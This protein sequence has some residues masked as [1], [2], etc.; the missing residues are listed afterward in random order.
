MGR[1]RKPALRA[2]VLITTVAMVV[3]NVLAEALPLFGRGTGE[4]SARYPVLITPAGYVFAIWGLI[5]LAMLAYGLAQF[6]DPLASMELPDRLAVPLIV[7]NFANVS[8]LVLWHALQIAW[9]VPVMVVLLLSL[10][11]AYVIARRT[12]PPAVPRLERWVVRGTLGLY[13][14]WVSVATIANVSIALYAAGWQGI[15]ISPV[16]WSV[17]VL[18][19]GAG[20]ALASQLVDADPVF[21][22]VFV[23]AFVGIAVN[24]PAAVVAW[25]A[26]VLAVV[27]VIA[28]VYVER[29]RWLPDGGTPE[30][31]LV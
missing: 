17:I 24:T 12:R 27:I 6:R 14:G 20:L 3:G 31:H 18:V 10:I 9:T 25:T 1:V 23:W 16:A 28:V 30:R 4:V 22:T 26:A 19:L 5:Y 8:W 13:L 2:L 21:A 15:G 29:G 11:A 7:S